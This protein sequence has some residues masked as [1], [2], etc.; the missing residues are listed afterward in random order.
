MPRRVMNRGETAGYIGRSATWFGS[1]LGDLYAVG[2][3]KP[4]PFLDQWD[5]HAVDRWLDRLGG[6]VPLSE[7]DE[8]DAWLRTANG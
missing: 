5:R 1:R 8:A 2:F 4:L 7:R 3:P 6:E